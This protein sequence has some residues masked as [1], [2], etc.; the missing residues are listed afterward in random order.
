MKLKKDN[1]F[2]KVG[3]IK[4]IHQPAKE[5][6]GVRVG[7]VTIGIATI[8]I[9]LAN[10]TPRFSEQMFKTMKKV[11]AGF[12]DVDLKFNFKLEAEAYI[13]TITAKTECRE[14]DTY[15]EE[16]GKKIVNSKIQ[17]IALRI[18]H[19][20]ATAFLKNYQGWASQMQVMR[21]FFDNQIA[22][23]RDYISKALYL[24]K[25]K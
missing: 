5:K 8:A 13:A 17:A 11:A 4:Y 24:P 1:I 15:S 18:A 9:P 14:D 23:E 3:E 20:M 10:F 21:D 25:E 22:K 2:V 7:E 19:R 16:I 6:K 12:P